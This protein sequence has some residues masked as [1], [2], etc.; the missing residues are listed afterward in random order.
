MIRAGEE[1]QARIAHVLM[2]MPEGRETYGLPRDPLGLAKK[3]TREAG[4]ATFA[5]ARNAV[6]WVRWLRAK[7]AQSSHCR[8]WLR[9]CLRSARPSRPSRRLEIARSA[10]WQ[11]SDPSSSSR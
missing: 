7:R 4:S 2:E 10:W 6:R 8:R 11:V 3:E 1:E 5:S 9:S